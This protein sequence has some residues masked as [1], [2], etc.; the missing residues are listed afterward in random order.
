MPPSLSLPRPSTA[1]LPR[2]CRLVVFSKLPPDALQRVVRRACDTDPALKGVTL[3][4]DAVKALVAAADG[5]ARVAL[6]VLELAASAGAQE[7]GPEAVLAAAQRR[8]LYDRDGDFHYDLISALHK[9]MRGGD[10]D[11]ALYY[12]ARMLHGG[13]E[14][15]YI[16]RRLIRFAS[17]DVGLAEPAALQ[18]VILAILLVVVLF[19]LSE[20]GFFEYATYT[21]PKKVHALYAL[22]KVLAKQNAR[23]AKKAHATYKTNTPLTLFPKS[24]YAFL[25]AVAADQ[26][27]HAIGMPEAGVVIAQAAAYLALAPKSCA[28]YSAFK[29]AMEACEKEPHAAVPLHLRNAPTKAMKGLGYGKGYVYNPSDGYGRGCE[30]GYLPQELGPH[31]RFWD[32]TDC[33]PGH[34]LKFCEPR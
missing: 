18:Q 10:V 25:Q 17:E 13:E 12:V 30:Q 4:D 8:S 21:P 27:V 24:A 20:K 34:T 16:T 14:P 7:V 31:R 29:A 26:A 23:Y 22:K 32:P 28:V 5:D 6:N 3:T 1:R 33:E 9:A 11:A 19:F 15:R 2:R